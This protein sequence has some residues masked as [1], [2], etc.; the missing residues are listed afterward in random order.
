[1]RPRPPRSVAAVTPRAPAAIGNQRRPRTCSSAPVGET[2]HNPAG[3]FGDK[4]SG[5][6]SLT[7]TPAWTSPATAVIVDPI[8]ASRGAGAFESIV[9][10]V[11]VET[12]T[13]AV[14]KGRV[15]RTAGA[16]LAIRASRRP[17]F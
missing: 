2:T 3:H 7:R 16:V 5:P 9:H 1:M 6:P 15:A 12:A 13:N 14:Q 10:A 11:T 17:T 4:T 8:P